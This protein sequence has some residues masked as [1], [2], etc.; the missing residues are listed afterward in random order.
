MPKCF[1]GDG[2]KAE[3]VCMLRSWASPRTVLAGPCTLFRHEHCICGRATSDSHLGTMQ[4]PPMCIPTLHIP[5]LKL[6]FS[7]GPPLLLGAPG[8]S[9]LPLCPQSKAPSMGLCPLCHTAG[10]DPAFQPAAFR[11]QPMYIWISKYW[12]LFAHTPM[13]SSS[14]GYL[15]RSVLYCTI[16]LF[17]FQ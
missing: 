10:A 5:A 15:I 1:E 16:S 14:V 6:C 7:M 17:L 4:V 2:E 9:S 3:S 12:L 11:E 13:A 8:H